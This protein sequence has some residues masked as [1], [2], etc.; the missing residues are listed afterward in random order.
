ML[1]TICKIE[2]CVYNAAVWMR[3]VPFVNG[4]LRGHPCNLV[5]RLSVLV[6]LTPRVYRFN[7]TAKKLN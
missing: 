1:H 4:I 3:L 2:L 6:I 5:K 7:I